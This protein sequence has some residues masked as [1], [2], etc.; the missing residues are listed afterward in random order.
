MPARCSLG[1]LGSLLALGSLYAQAP[2]RPGASSAAP[3]T[4]TP[5]LKA[6]KDLRWRSIGPANQAGRIPMVVGIPGDRSTYYVGAAA[7]GLFKTSNGGVTFEP[8]FDDQENASIGDLAIAPS[9]HSILYL[10][11]GE[12]NPRNSASVGDGVYKSLDGGKSW[13]KLGLENSEKI[14]RIRIDPANPEIVFVC[15]LGRTWGPNQERGLFKTT[16]GGKSWRKILYVDELTGCSDVD[17]DP[18]NSNV[19]WAGMHRHQRWPWYFTSGGGGTG[20][21]LSVDG[22]ESWTRLSGKANGRGLPEG[23]MDR[24]GISV[25]R[26]DPNVV[27]VVSETKSEGE[28]WRTEDGGKTWQTVNR[29]PNINFRPFYYSDVRADPANPNVVYTLSG[30]LNKSQDGGRTFQRIGGDIHGD[31]QAMWIDPTDGNY[32]LEGSDGGWQ[33]SYDAGRSWEVVNTVS[34]AQFYHVNYDME[35]PYNL[36][37]GLQDNGHW[38]GPSRTLSNQGN[39]K[40]AWVTVSGGDGFFAVPDLKEPSLVYSASQGGG[41][42][43]TDMRTGDQR[44]IHPYPRRVGS[45]G[46]SLAEHKYRFNWNAPIVL[47]PADSKTVYFGGNVLFRT[48]NY[49][50]SWEVIS[51]DLSTNDKKKQGSSGGPIVTDNTAAEFHS[52]ILT[53]AP[54]PKDSK[55][56]WVGTDDGNIQVTRDGGGSWVNTVRNI[57][58]LAPNSWVSTIDASPHD[59]G[60]ALVAASHWQTGDY[61][62]Y[63]YL[64]RDYGQTW[65]RISGNLPAR[66][67]A[68]VV[69]QDPRNPNL[70][71]AGTEFGIFA[72]WNLG[73]Q[74]HSLRNGLPAA[75]VRD[76]VIHPRDNDLIIATHGRG[77]YVLDDLTPLQQLSGALATE[78]TLFEPPPA[79]RYVMWSADGNLGQKVWR[80]EN[81]PYGAV[82]SYFVKDT[83]KGL[84]WTIKDAQGQ[85]IRTLRDSVAAPGVH[86]LA[87]DLRYDVSPP[88]EPVVAGASGGGGGGFGGGGAPYVVPGSYTVTLAAGGKELSRPLTV[89]ADPRAK[90]PLGDLVAQRDAALELRELSAR[91]GRVLSRTNNL[92]Q[93]LTNLGAV[94]RQNAPT[95]R[96]A[97]DEARGTLEELREFRDS[98]LA[99]PLAGL[100]Y[101]QYPRLREEVQSLYGS[102]TRSL[103]RPTDPQMVRKGELDG[104]TRAAEQRLNGILTGRI[105]KLN[106]MLKNLPHIIVA[107]GGIS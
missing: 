70:L 85:V 36:C 42:V 22:G 7:G 52:T 103:T 41:I 47:D 32:I 80:G 71:Y 8:L 79:L 50:Q 92:M 55:V 72:S 48:R 19:V 107:G 28:L 61:A 56:I 66:G 33:V 12:G 49:G 91:V 14:P 63:L 89:E 46:D 26:A 10:G 20:V 69:R 60:T 38:C 77:L 18:G 37:G 35:K 68:H 84:R 82:L 98:Q 39:R 74:W 67:W 97:I 44:S 87:W 94:L 30:S 76:L 105:A 90:V 2:A 86:R 96:A 21:Y 106:A 6:L 99:R 11:T 25:H 29:D 5:E 24:I 104:E 23:D 100:G 59:A 40:N 95:E 16:D 51:P 81:P 62:P 17:I 88:G 102:V 34:F 15:A 3:L 64:T 65:T 78:L 73:R 83:L 31:H 57:R 58:D 27:Y 54:S 101:R 43:L 75:P 1:I 93:Q 53:I 13:K 4:D 45:A 9:N